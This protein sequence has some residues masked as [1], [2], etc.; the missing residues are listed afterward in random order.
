MLRIY[1]RRLGGIDGKKWCVEG[2]DILGNKMPRPDAQLTRM[3]VSLS[4]YQKFEPVAPG[5]NYC[6]RKTWI[7]S[8]I[9]IN[10][11][12]L[13]G[14]FSP[15]WPAVHEHFPKL[16]W[17]SGILRESQSHAYHRNRLDDIWFQGSIIDFIDKFRFNSIRG[18]HIGF[19][20]GM[21]FDSFVEI[22]IIVSTQLHTFQ[23]R[24]LKRWV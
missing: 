16:L 15:G 3:A 17:W 13:L 21:S 24:G 20:S 1:C 7:T 9:R 14:Y 23:R 19:T 10:I 5:D 12:S 22:P 8:I 6:L 11:V 4:R 2:R 18:L